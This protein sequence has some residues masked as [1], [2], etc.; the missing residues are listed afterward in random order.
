M[1]KFVRF[2]LL[3]A[4]G[5][6][7]VLC[8]R[9]GFGASLDNSSAG[10]SLEPQS[11]RE[12]FNEG[13]RL[14]QQTNL[15][16]AE[17][18]F[19]RALSSQTEAFQSPSLYN[20]G[21]VRFTQGAEELKKGPPATAT[22]ARGQAA[23]QQASHAIE[24]ANDALA[25]TSVEKLVASYLQGRGA[26]RELRAALKAVK[27]ALQVYGK[28]LNKWERSSGD[29]K[30]ALELNQTDNDARHNAEVVDRS[31]AKLVDRIQQ[32]QQMAQAMGQQE[33]E[34]GEKMKQ[35]KGRIPAPDMPPGGAGEDDE[36]ED[37]PNGKEPGQKEEGPTKEGGEMPLSPEQASWLLEAFGSGRLLLPVEATKGGTPKAKDPW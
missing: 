33:K 24:A 29:F 5:I 32:L 6:A 26:R 4:L 36:E 19:E 14:L 22:A 28:T 27:A 34:L 30:S 15:W 23:G 31:I 37:F 25:D 20:L 17:Y 1:I 3:I 16:R 12:L 8:S 2:L 35:M 10:G 21:H 9:T 18:C 13:T 7:G 11:P